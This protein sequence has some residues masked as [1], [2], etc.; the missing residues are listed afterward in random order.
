[1]YGEGL[2]VG[3][4]SV[5]SHMSPNARFRRKILRTNITGEDS[6]FVMRR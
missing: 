4:T 6:V 3:L 1:M 5:Y 2:E